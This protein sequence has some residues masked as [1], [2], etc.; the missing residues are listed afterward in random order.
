MCYKLFITYYITWGKY[1]GN[2]SN[3]SHVSS[4]QGG[5][6]GFSP[7]CF[8]ERFTFSLSLL[9]SVPTLCYLF[10]L[11]VY[12]CLMKWPQSIQNLFHDYQQVSV[13]FFILDIV[14]MGMS[15][16][17]MRWLVFSKRKQD[18]HVL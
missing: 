3:S 11:P 8:I 16:R 10:L 14:W 2:F 13:V 6:Q 15:K 18:V 9:F 1:W 5:T 17:D 7:P 12:H 4:L